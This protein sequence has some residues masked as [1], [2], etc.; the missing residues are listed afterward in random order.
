MLQ[1]SFL[2]LMIKMQYENDGSEKKYQAYAM[3]AI[4][5]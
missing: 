5:F 2:A 1:L 4:N 3:F